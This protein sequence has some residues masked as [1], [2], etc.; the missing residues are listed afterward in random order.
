MV[1]AVVFAIYMW[2]LFIGFHNHVLEIRVGDPDLSMSST[3]GAVVRIYYLKTPYKVSVPG[4]PAPK[5]DISL[6]YSSTSQFMATR[7]DKIPV[8]PVFVGGWGVRVHRQ[9]YA[10]SSR[11]ATARFIINRRP[12]ELSGYT[13]RSGGT[14]WTLKQGETLQV[15]LAQV[16]ALLPIDNTPPGTPT[17]ELAPVGPDASGK[18]E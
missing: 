4:Q 7:E 10:T 13:L 1:A 9:V 2:G 18:T 14:T 16:P 8:Q 11:N 12:F 6:W 3:A 17:P 5:P 15:N